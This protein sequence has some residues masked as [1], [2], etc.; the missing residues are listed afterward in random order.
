[1]ATNLQVVEK[2]N[3]ISKKFSNV[4]GSKGGML[5]HDILEKAKLQEQRNLVVFPAR[6]RGRGGVG[7]L[8]SIG[9]NRNY[10]IP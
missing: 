4:K 5:V 10:F 3:T 9:G 8:E 6:A 1:M 7:T 2:R